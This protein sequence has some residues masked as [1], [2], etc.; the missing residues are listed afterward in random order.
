MNAFDLAIVAIIALS[1]LF[2]FARGIIREVIALGAWIAGFIAAIAYAGALANAL[3]WL[4]MTPVAK[5]ALAF[6]LIL[7]VVL[8]VGALIARVLAG[9]IRAVGLGFMDR[10]LGL[11]FGVARG[12]IVVVAF[13]LVAGVTALPKRDWWQNSTLGEPL[14]Q[15]ALSLKPYLPRAWADRLD[16]SPAGVSSAGLGEHRPCA[17]S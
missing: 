15:A 9:L 3:P 17:E 2:A 10:I 14:A 13:A 11:V 16:F 5:Q 8:I 6:V 4:N 12:L 7:V 1:A